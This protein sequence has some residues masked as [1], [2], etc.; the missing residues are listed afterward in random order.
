M[1]TIAAIALFVG[2]IAAAGGERA[3]AGE[4]YTDEAR[5][6]SLTVPDDWMKIPG[7]M[8]PIGLGLASPRFDQTGGMCMVASQ[9]VTETRNQSQ[10][11]L[12]E[13][14]AGGINEA[15]WRSMMEDKD[16]RDTTVESRSELRSDRRVFLATVR[17]ITKYS[18]GEVPI[19]IEIA[20]HFVPGLFLMSQCYANQAEFA[21]EQNDIKTVTDTLNPIAGVVARLERPGGSSTLL[22]FAGPQFDGQKWELTHDAPDLRLGPT[23]SFALRGADQWQICDRANYKGNCRS[24]NGASAVALGGRP[25]AIASARRIAGSVS[26]VGVVTEVG[27]ALLKSAREKAARPQ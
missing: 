8:G 4:K 21:L 10:A 5:R 2:M 7:G 24:I 27:I 25:L 1:R 14:M 15:F 26:K 11:A 3:L 9:F 18:K 19:R 13:E 20:L 22:L 16:T 12:N 23:A 17:Q 6:F